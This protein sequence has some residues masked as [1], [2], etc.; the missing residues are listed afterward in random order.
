MIY[1]TPKRVY[2]PRAFTAEVSKLSFKLRYSSN[3][4]AFLKRIMNPTV[5]TSPG[6][7]RLMFASRV[8]ITS[9][10]PWYISNQ[11]ESESGGVVW[12]YVYVGGY[13]SKVV[14]ELRGPTFRGLPE[15]V[16]RKLLIPTKSQTGCILKRNNWKWLRL[17][18]EQEGKNVKALSSGEEGINV[19]GMNCTSYDH[20]FE[21][22]I[23]K[24]TWTPKER[25]E[26]NL[27]PNPNSTHRHLATNTYPKTEN[28]VVSS[29]SSS[30]R[31]T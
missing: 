21:E 16:K 11:N 29:P 22:L 4:C 6:Q 2:F 15:D 12:E 3:K 24:R 8:E 1:L 13:E 30:R 25:K 7:P 18:L 20:A 19:L 31:S 9:N 10:S 26:K 14:D 23:D 17:G 5:V 27:K 28:F